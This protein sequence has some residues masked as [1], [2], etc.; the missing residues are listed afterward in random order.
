[1][2]YLREPHE[3]YAR[4]FEII[5][6]E[7][8]LA[9][10][11]EGDARIATRIIH[12]CGEPEIARSLQ[13]S[14]DFTSSGHRALSDGAPIICDGEM[15]AAGIIRRLLPAGNDVLTFIG[16]P[17]TALLANQ[18]GTTRS[19]AAVELWR[20]RLR[21]AVIAIGSA[22]TALF[23]LLEIV[24]AAGI[25]P[26][27]IIAFPVGFVGAAESKDALIADPHG[28]A[29]A[30]LTGRRGGAAMAAAAINALAT[31]NRETES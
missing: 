4:S 20:P 7:T 18:L 21:G 26:A 5:R 19:A 31:G 22:P 14:R 28:I 8:D 23:R 13:F 16:R 1:M 30:T 17:E 15:T 3:I 10:F 2:T 25:A 27:A 12:A 24:E 11:S 9:R 6:S 29:Y